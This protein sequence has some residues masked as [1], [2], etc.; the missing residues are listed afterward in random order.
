[1]NERTLQNPIG[2]NAMHLCVDMQR[3]FAEP[4]EWKM[5]WSAQ[6]LPHI[7]ALVASRPDKTIFTRFIPAQKPGEGQGMW[8]RYYEH[9]ASMTVEIL[10][11]DMLELVPALAR[12]SPPATLVDKHVYSPWL[13]TDLHQRLQQQG[14][15]TLIISGGETDVCI[16]ATVLGA[17]DLGYRVVLAKD[18]LCSSSD[19]AHDSAI[20]LY[21]QRYS[22]QVEPIETET[23]LRH[24]RP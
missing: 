21:H 22:I 6:V 23:I 8:K 20:D 18:A 2:T 7:T 16:L 14:V 13:E 5:P 10:G 15:T 17:V 12:F 24:W 1:M 3:M 19:E 4:T 9:W 11:A